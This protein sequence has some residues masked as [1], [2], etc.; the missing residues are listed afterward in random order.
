MSFDLNAL[1]AGRL[2][3]LSDEDFRAALAGVLEMQKQDRRENQ[4]L[5]FN[6]PTPEAERVIRSTAKTLGVGGG[7]R[8]GKTTNCIVKWVALAT[9]IFPRGLED[10]LREQFK[11]PLRVRMVVESLTTTLYPIILPKLQWWQWSGLPPA[12][13]EKG[14][15]GWIP[16]NCL[17][18]GDWASSWS[19]KLR[20]LTVLCRDPADPERIL[21]KST[22]QFMSF[23]QDSS[24]F[25]SGDFDIIHHDEPPPSAI[26]RENEA[27]VMSVGGT[28]M[29]SMT[30][31][32]DPSIPVDWIYDE[33]YEPGLPG[34]QHNPGV[35]WIELDT[36]RNPH[37]DQASIAAK[38]I[39]KDASWIQTRVKGQPIR[40]SNRI[41]PLFTDAPQHWCH[42][43]GMTVIPVEGRCTE[44]R[45]EAIPFCH[46]EDFEVRRN[47]P[48]LFVIDPHPRKPHMW[49][50]LQVDPQDDL[51]VVAEGQLDGDP[52]EVRSRADEIESTFGLDVTQ[53]LM[54]PNMGASPASSKRGVTWR[55]EFYDAG[56]ECDLA[57]DS[58]VGRKKINEYLK[59]DDRTD[60]P[61]LHV[62]S[63]CA[64]TIFQMKRYA[65][66]EHRRSQERD[67]KEKPREKYDDYPTMLKYAL[68]SNP[69]FSLLRHGAPVLRRPGTRR[70]A[71]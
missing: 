1:S 27:R 30:W 2:D 15:W 18:D 48:A 33:V 60:R 57:D 11:G 55:G 54:D 52:M 46:V 65:W 47:W 17:V 59:P 22:A 45:G 32:D 58:D 14:H 19:E 24:D 28:M 36:T 5:Y 7:N 67:L 34:L 68:N 12:D 37:L 70:G 8:S 69:V 63:R 23:D 64:N 39:G 38:A 6:P 13:G 35:E 3:S 53:R 40:F 50:H 41:H 44:C 20:M 29:L 10:P 66:A 43:C 9:G 31:P 21:G 62:H 49:L 56:L 61:R 71:Y 16:R 42:S 25:A 26:W 4:L 51:W